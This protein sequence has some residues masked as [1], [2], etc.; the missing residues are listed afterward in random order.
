VTINEYVER[1][2]VRVTNVFTND[3][4]PYDPTNIWL[5][6]RK[7]DGTTTTY[8]F[9]GGGSP[10]VKDSTGNYHADLDTTDLP[11]YWDYKWYSTGTG[12]A[13]AQGTFYVK[14]LGES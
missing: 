3:G 11:G 14:R 4:A 12:P 13:A 9:G 7:P 5:E 6:V 8:Q 1:E 10:I 2:M